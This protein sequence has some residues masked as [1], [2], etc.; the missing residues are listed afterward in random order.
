VCRPPSRPRI[1]S[2]KDQGLPDTRPIRQSQP[3]ARRNPLG[4]QDGQHPRLTLPQRGSI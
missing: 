2:D 4:T 3:G 1:H